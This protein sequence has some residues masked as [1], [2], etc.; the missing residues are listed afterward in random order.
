MNPDGSDLEVFASGFRNPYDLAF[1]PSGE[2]F[3]GDNNPDALDD[4]LHYL[5]PEELNYVRQG[6]HYGFP[7]AFGFMGV[8]GE[9]EPPVVEFFP[10]VATTGLAYYGVSTFPPPYHN[11][12]FMALWGTA[13]PTPQERSLTNG[14]MVVFVTL[15]PTSNG[16]YR[17]EWDVFAWFRQGSDYRPIDVLVGEDG[18]LYIA[19]WTTSTVYRVAYVGEDAALPVPPTPTPEI[20]PTASAE[21]LA[22]GESVYLNGAQDAPSCVSCHLLDPNLRGLGPS[23]LGLRDVANQRVSGQGTM[24][25]VRR[26]ITHPNDYIVPGYNAGYMYQDYAHRLTDDQLDALVAYVLSLEAE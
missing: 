19:E 6:R 5:P 20:L 22:L 4:T 12:V 8:G 15:N 1:S 7:D 17:G 23:L 21:T 13:A 25:Y 16:G 11:G 24:D 2:L 9:N 26:S 3:A 14:R 18:A 10:S